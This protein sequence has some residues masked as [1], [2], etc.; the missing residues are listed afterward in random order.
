M[1]W[2]VIGIEKFNIIA[3]HVVIGNQ[4][5]IVGEQKQTVSSVITALMVRTISA[6]EVLSMRVDYFL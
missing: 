3:H 1:Y 2:Q 4:I 6:S 5:I